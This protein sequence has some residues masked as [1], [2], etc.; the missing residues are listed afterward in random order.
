MKGQGKHISFF[1]LLLIAIVISP[2][3][4][5]HHHDNHLHDAHYFDD[6]NGLLSDHVF[7]DC[8]FCEFI[9]PYFYE[10]GSDGPY[11]VNSANFQFTAKQEPFFKTTS[12]FHYLLRGPPELVN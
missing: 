12:H 8:D 11:A 9:T 3:N 6:S 7:D 5:L 1:L 4:L 10:I 2:W